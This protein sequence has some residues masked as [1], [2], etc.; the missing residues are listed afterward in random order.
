MDYLKVLKE[1]ADCRENISKLY[2]EIADYQKR[3][4]DVKDDTSTAIK[5]D[6]EVCKARIKELKQL[7]KDIQNA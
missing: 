6:V 2:D 7:K 1:I 4:A 5:L 3:V